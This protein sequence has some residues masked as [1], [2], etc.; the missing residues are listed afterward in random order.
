MSRE[1]RKNEMPHISSASAVEARVPA[2][3]YDRPRRRSYDTVHVIGPGA[4]GRAL[5]E[6]FAGDRRRVIAVTDSTA[7]LH[8]RRGI[9]PRA[10]IE[11]KRAGRALRDHAH[12][13]PIASAQAIGHVDADVVA[14]ASATDLDRAEWTAALGAALARGACVASAAKAALCEAGAEW[15][16]GEHRRRA[17][18]NAVL[19]G[20]GRSFISELPELQ[21]R[22]R[23]IAIVG[24]ASTTAMLD[25]IERGG[26]LAE[27]ITEAQRLGFL[28]PDP[29]LD[30]RGTDAAVKLAIVAGIV[31]G[32]RIDPRT[33]PCTD[34]RA[35]DLLAVRAR[36]R[37]GAATRLIGRLSDTGA[38][39]VSYEEVA[40]DS[41]L[42]AP[43][44]RVVYEY[45]L[46]RDERRIHLGTGLG[47]DATAGALWSDIRALAA[48]AASRTRQ[49]AGA[50]R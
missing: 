38:L 36:A 35:I 4:V 47:A 34:I 28:E 49:T 14:D 45:R 37:R 21:Q 48:E 3:G 17:G 27:G 32:R 43:C 42:A 29:E 26:T 8:D 1:P 13:Q 15:F 22:T 50:A 18:C 2:P 23:G 5:L 9:D 20:T 11:W 40:R 25:V 44:G 46:D 33:I 30:L 16:T 7:T 31:T 10:V 6:R 39:R 19:G 41:V 12:A 24:N